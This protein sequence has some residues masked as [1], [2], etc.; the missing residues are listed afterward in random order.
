M[1]RPL[2]YHSGVHK[3]VHSGFDL[4]SFSGNSHSQT[5]QRLGGPSKF[6][7]EIDPRQRLSSSILSQPGDCD[8]FGEIKSCPQPKDSLPGYVDRQSF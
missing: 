7:S 2:N 8:K 4:G 5:P 6:L 3:G 1:L